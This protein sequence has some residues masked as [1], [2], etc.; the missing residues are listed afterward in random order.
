[1]QVCLVVVDS[2]ASPFRQGFKDNGQRNR[3]LNGLAQNFIKLATSYD[4][5]VCCNT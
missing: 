1:M 4:L 2:I 5:A 3:L